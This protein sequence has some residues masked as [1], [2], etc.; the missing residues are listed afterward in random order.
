MS[1]T[2]EYYGL[3]PTPRGTEYRT[4]IIATASQT[5]FT[6]TYTV[7]VVDVY[8]NGSLLANAAYTATNGTTITLVTPAALNDVVKIISRTTALLASGTSYTQSQSDARYATIASVELKADIADVVK[9]GIT[10]F[11]GNS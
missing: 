8:K 10:Y 1:G 4:E 2:F 9:R 5:L 3:P 7:G 6:A 11:M